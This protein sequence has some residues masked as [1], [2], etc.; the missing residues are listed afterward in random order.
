MKKNRKNRLKEKTY[1]IRGMIEWMAVFQQV[2][3]AGRPV[4]VHF[5]GGQITG[6]GETP[7]TYTTCCP[8]TQRLIEETKEFKLKQITLLSEKYA[9]PDIEEDEPDEDETDED[10]TDDDPIYDEDYDDEDQTW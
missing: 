7:A 2:K 1:G 4:R 3:I 10:E 6:F 5:T 8:V 9:N